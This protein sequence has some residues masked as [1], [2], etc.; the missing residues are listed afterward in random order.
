MRQ[1]SEGARVSAAGRGDLLRSLGDI[2]TRLDTDHAGVWM[3]EPRP[4]VPLE[5][6]PEAATV[7]Y[8]SDRAY[9]VGLLRA[10]QRQLVKT[11]THGVLG[12]N[13]SVSV[14]E[15]PFFPTGT[16]QT[17]RIA[18]LSEHG[19]DVIA[20]SALA[21]GAPTG[22]HRH[23][24]PAD[25]YVVSPHLYHLVEDYLTGSTCDVTEATMRMGVG[26]ECPAGGVALAWVRDYLGVTSTL[27]DPCT[28]CQLEA[29]LDHTEPL[30]TPIW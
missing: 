3:V 26:F 21:G 16:S 13:A 7:A 22:K 27:V 24:T 2:F 12:A 18:E 1:A 9:H 20:A 28:L 5:E 15:P 14:T 19:I 11:V 23:S 4:E 8:C 10:T 30:P 17:A 25:S 29:S 6:T